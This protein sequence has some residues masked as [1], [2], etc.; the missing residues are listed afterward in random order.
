MTMRALHRD[1]GL[2][3]EDFAELQ[4]RTGADEFIIGSDLYEH[5]H[6]LRS[7]EIIMDAWTGRSK[8]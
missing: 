2:N 5:S 1:R 4:A 7:Y 8:N 6:R 3:G